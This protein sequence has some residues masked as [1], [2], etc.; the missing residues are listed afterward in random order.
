MFF[1]D[2]DAFMVL[3][4]LILYI[5]MLGGVFFIASTLFRLVDMLRWEA[6]RRKR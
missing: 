5:V 3:E 4:A 6:K 1:T 2:N